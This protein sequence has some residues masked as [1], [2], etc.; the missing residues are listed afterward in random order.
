MSSGIKQFTSFWR[1]RG[2]A[3]IEQLAD[4]I[5]AIDTPTFRAM[6]RAQVYELN[7]QLVLAWHNALDTGDPTPIVQFARAT[8]LNRAVQHTDISELMQ[9]IDILR[10]HLWALMSQLYVNGDWDMDVV[11]QV[12]RW[13]HEERKAIMSS[14]F[15]TWQEAETR[16]AEREQALEEQRRLIQQLSTPIVPIHEGILVLPLVGALDP[17]RATQIVEAVLDKIVEHQADVL[18]LDIT[19]VP[20]VDTDVANYIIQMARAVT[21]LGS[22]VVLVGIG[23]EIAQTMVQLGVEL[24]NI[25][26]LANLQAGIAY[27]L[28]QQGFTIRP[29][30]A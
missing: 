18:I 3:M 20:V 10:K 29:T 19:G 26:T 12:E 25:T 22:Q 14:Y 1:D 24:R 21:L 8:A 17:R 4:D 23:S 28:G 9:V 11:E 5:A 7:R 15:E 2:D 30:A 27:A 6:P 13:L 16:L